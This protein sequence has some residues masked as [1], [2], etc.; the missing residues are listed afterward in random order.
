MMEVRK[1]RPGI[2]ATMMAAFATVIAVLPVFLV[3]GLAVQLEEDLGMTATVLGAAVAVYWAVS[4]L[5]SIT[6]G[7][8]AQILG[9]RKGM[10]LST[11]LGLASLLGISLATPHWTWLFLWL[12]IA[13]AG[14]AL[15]HPLSNGLIAREV[16]IKNR[17][18]A[19]GLKQAATQAA[20]LIAGMSV[21]ILALTVG[22]KWAFVGAAVV[23]VVLLPM[24]ARL[25]RRQHRNGTLEVHSEL[26]KSPRFP[27]GCGLS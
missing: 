3:G 24:L 18:F 6:G 25:V 7:Y 4:A 1:R 16:A 5:L 26:G 8:V 10:L 9:A 19:F 27:V 23:A 11:A 2:R 21:P 22:W 12:A 20:S 13:G 17:A 15:S 14:N